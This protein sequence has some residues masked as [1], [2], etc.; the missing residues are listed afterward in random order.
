MRVIS[1]PGVGPEKADDTDADAALLARIEAGDMSAMKA[2]Y[3]AHSAA[4]HRFVRSRIRDEFEAADIVHETM[5][6]VW[7]GASGF[8][9]RSSVLSWILTLARNKTV[10]HLRKQSRVSLAEPDETIPDGDPDAETVL[11]AAQDAERVRACVSE[12]P[13]RQRSAVHL[14]FFQDLTCAQIAEIEDVP[15]GT[16]KTRIYH[17][18]KLLMRCLARCGKKE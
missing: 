3:V 7:R 13:E 5:L 2:L 15:E 9:H 16:V 14:A 6:S 12:L 8:Q 18:K 17:A 10:D 1:N 4:V 11:G